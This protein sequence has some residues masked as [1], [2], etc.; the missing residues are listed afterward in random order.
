MNDSWK[1]H[2]NFRTKLSSPIYFAS[3]NAAFSTYYLNMLLKYLPPPGRYRRSKP[4]KHNKR[5]PHGSVP[6]WTHV[7]RIPGILEGWMDFCLGTFGP[8]NWENGW[9][10][11]QHLTNIWRNKKW[12][13]NRNSN[14][15]NNN[16]NN[17]DND[18]NNNNNNNNNTNGNN[19]NN[20]NNNNKKNKNNNKNKNKNNLNFQF[21]HTG[22]STISIFECVPWLRSFGI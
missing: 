21:I 19:N 15:N 3:S 22:P 12:T 9:L 10:V 17:K 1:K 20:N 14:N 8:W 16:N 18:N 13:T 2:H 7:E 11:Q 6:D 5:H 4:P